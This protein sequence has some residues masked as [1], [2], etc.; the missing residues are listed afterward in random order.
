[1]TGFLRDAL[2]RHFADPNNIEQYDLRSIVWRPDERTGILIEDV[3][4]WRQGL[5]EKRPAVIIK[6]NAYRNMRTTIADLSGKDR[7]GG[8]NFVTLWVGSNTL[9]CIERTGIAADVLATEVQRYCTQNAQVFKQ[10]LGLIAFSVTEVGAISELEEATEN[11]VVPV[12][13]G[14]AYEETWNLRKEAP[15]IWRV[16]LAR[17]CGC[18]P[19]RLN[20]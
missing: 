10:K 6:R 14:W 1:M 16:S 18:E 4:R 11:Q 13:V 7:W 17:L 8:Y 2:Y 12:T 5:V 19:A 20:R 9:F 3:D 15:P